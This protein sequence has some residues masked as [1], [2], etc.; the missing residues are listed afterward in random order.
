MFYNKHTNSGKPN[1]RKKVSHMN[2][3]TSDCQVIAQHTHNRQTAEISATHSYKHSDTHTR[4]HTQ[5][6]DKKLCFILK[7]VEKFDIRVIF[8]SKLC[9]EPVN[10]HK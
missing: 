10:E 5:Y 3:S 6:A 8:S 7:Q 4:T 9:N 2:S 1:N